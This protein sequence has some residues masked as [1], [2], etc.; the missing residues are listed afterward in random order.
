MT[1]SDVF[2][3]PSPSLPVEGSVTASAG[4]FSS[5]W[6]DGADIPVSCDDG[7]DTPPRTVTLPV[8]MLLA[9]TCT[10]FA[11]A[12]Y[13]LRMEMTSGT[14]ASSIA[15]RLLSPS[16]LILSVLIASSLRVSPGSSC[17]MS[18]TLNV[19]DLTLHSTS[20]DIAS[21]AL[22]DTL[23][24]TDELVR[25][26]STVSS[27]GYSTNLG[28]RSLSSRIASDSYADGGI[29]QCISGSCAN[30]ESPC[31]LSQNPPPNMS[32]AMGP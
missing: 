25:M 14:A 8:L 13:P 32:W 9:T 30:S 7:A 28:M 12:L 22:S 4:V 27:I 20:V 17:T 11:F 18:F 29:P 19:F 5:A 31:R 21:L 16:L 10:F 1:A 26:Y 6:S 3:V 23:P 24:P 15:L 2:S